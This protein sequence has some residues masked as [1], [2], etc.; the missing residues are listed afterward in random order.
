MFKISHNKH[1]VPLFVI[2]CSVLI[3]ERAS[4]N[5]V[6]EKL[7]VKAYNCSAFA[8]EA[9]I[10]RPLQPFEYPSYQGPTHQGGGFN[11]G[12]S[13]MQPVVGGNSIGPGG[14]GGGLFGVPSKQGLGGGGLGGGLGGATQGG[15]GLGGGNASATPQPQAS[16]KKVQKSKITYQTQD[17]TEITNL[18]YESVDPKSWSLNHARPKI[19]KVGSILIITQTQKNHDEIKKLLD[20]L[21]EARKQ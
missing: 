18:I 7:I 4:S 16:K 6:R 8:T 1:V 17:V 13:G 21:K 11:G 3:V 19:R 14:G 15:G 12:F 10:T 9:T 5:D 2:A 20:M